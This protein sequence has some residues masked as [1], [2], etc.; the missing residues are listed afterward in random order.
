MV[1]GLVLYDGAYEPMPV[2]VLSIDAWATG[3]KNGVVPCLF[4]VAYRHEAFRFIE[5][6]KQLGAHGKRTYATLA[7]QKFVVLFTDGHE[8]LPQE[9]AK[10]GN[11]H[12]K[13]KTYIVYKDSVDVSYQL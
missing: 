12:H 5:E 2:S 10:I 13:P 6:L 8:V 3:R 11:K 1:N 9:F 4:S 7:N